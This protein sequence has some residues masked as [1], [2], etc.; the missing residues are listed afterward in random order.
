MKKN[1]FTKSPKLKGLSNHR[2]PTSAE[3]TRKDIFVSDVLIQGKLSTTSLAQI[4]MHHL[5]GNV[6]TALGEFMGQCLVRLGAVVPIAV[7]RG[8]TIAN[9]NGH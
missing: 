4:V 7:V 5:K 9:R 6:D 3:Q 1:N 8:T 2:G